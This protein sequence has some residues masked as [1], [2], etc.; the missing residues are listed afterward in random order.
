MYVSQPWSW[1]YQ[2]WY[3]IVKMFTPWK[4]QN[5]SPSWEMLHKIG[6]NFQ[7]RYNGFLKE[8]NLPKDDFKRWQDQNWHSA[9]KEAH[10]STRCYCKPP[11]EMQTSSINNPMFSWLSNWLRWKVLEVQEET[12]HSA[13]NNPNS[14][15]DSNSYQS[16]DK[17]YLS[18]IQVEG[19]YLEVLSMAHWVPPKVGI[20]S[21]VSL[22]NS[23]GW[24]S[25]T[26]LTKPSCMQ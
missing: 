5:C 19:R 6:K 11:L 26:F 8:L 1:Q 22:V 25:H 2:E 14:N 15:T 24:R 9:G 21:L 12:N 20:I 10:K 16:S 7:S 4:H 18:P 13:Q 23:S 3:C 17:F